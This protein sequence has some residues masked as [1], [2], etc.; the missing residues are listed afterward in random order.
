MALTTYQ[1]A[2]LITLVT[3]QNVFLVKL[4]TSATYQNTFLIA[5]ISF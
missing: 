2:S 3:S 4:I 5:F 1:N